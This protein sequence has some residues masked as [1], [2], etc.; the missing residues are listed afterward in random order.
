M[1]RARKFT[2]PLYESVALI[3]YYRKPVLHLEIV[4]L[5]QALANF[6]SPEPAVNLTIRLDA[7]G[8]LATSNAVLVSNVT[9]P[10]TSGGVAGALKGL[11]GKK[12]KEDAVAGDA[13]EDM[14]DPDGDTVEAEI[15][16]IILEAEKSDTTDKK[17]KT[18]KA[19]KKS[20]VKAKAEKVALRFRE[21]QLGVKPMS[22]EEK[23]TTL[24]RRVQNSISLSEDG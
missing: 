17:D 1:P 6:T 23:R 13:E 3:G 7:R 21:K 20:K 2:W 15:E 19:E 22:G 18:E 10:E 14:T 5:E 16:E 11:F 8:Y 24:A 12:I 4:E 9:E